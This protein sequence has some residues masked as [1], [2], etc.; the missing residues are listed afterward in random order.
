VLL[1][2]TNISKWLT[3]IANLGVLIGLI[4]VSY[5][6]NQNSK[7][8]RAALINDGSGFENQFWAD[9][10]GDAPTSVIAMAVECP[11][12]MSYADYM[13]MDAYLFTSLNIVYRNYELA[14]EG[15]FTQSDW[16]KDVEGYTHW[17]LGNDFGRAWW[18]KEGQFFF[19]E[20]FSNHVGKQLKGDGSD[21]LGYWRQIRAEIDAARNANPPISSPCQ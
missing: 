5:E 9:V 10:M 15:L 16:K 6:L 2:T 3:V 17:Y 14:Q 4:L 7:L 13:A 19:D 1:N 20:N 8:A 11:E 21:S 18:S 12:R